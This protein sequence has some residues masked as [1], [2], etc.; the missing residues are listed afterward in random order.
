[1]TETEWLA[2]EDPLREPLSFLDG[3][4]SDRKLRL[5]SC[6]CCRRLWDTLTDSERAVVEAAERII[7]GART[8]P[9]IALVDHATTHWNSPNYPFRYSWRSVGCI[10]H[11]VRGRTPAQMQWWISGLAGYSGTKTP[12]TRQEARAQMILLRD[13]VGNPFRPVAFSPEWRSETAVILAQ[14]MYELREFSAMPILADALQD[15]GCDNEELLNHCRDT[16][17]PHIRGCWV[18]DLVL[19][20]Q[21][22]FSTERI[23]EFGAMQPSHD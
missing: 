10:F 14:Q 2:C 12:A 8:A 22:P 1:M 13:V 19:E 6:G 23:W 16:T 18:V 4:T 17:Q 3:T 20:K 5:F 11:G 9:D 7:D 15:A 21:F